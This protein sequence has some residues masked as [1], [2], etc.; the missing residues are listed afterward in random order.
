MH[1][2]HQQVASA[3]FFMDP[4]VVYTVR[5][6]WPILCPCGWV[7]PWFCCR[8]LQLIDERM[9][10]LVRISAMPFFPSTTGTAWCRSTCCTGENLSEY[11][12]KATWSSTVTVPYGF[13]Y[14][15]HCTNSTKMPKFK[16]SAQKCGNFSWQF[17][18]IRDFLP[19]SVVLTAVHVHNPLL[20]A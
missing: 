3:A 10:L 6:Y 18:P 15:F 8:N 1:V 17:S 12:H 9:A 19:V 5:W 20:Q 2:T 14:C 4:C 11:I 7:S 16:N 13:S